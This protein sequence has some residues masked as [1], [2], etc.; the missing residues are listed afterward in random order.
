M[1]LLNLEGFEN[2]AKVVGKKLDGLVRGTRVFALEVVAEVMTS[3]WCY[4]IVE[5]DRKESG[6]LI[7]KLV[8]P[9]EF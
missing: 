9:C 7:R 4:A 6:V 8:A 1:F 3:Q 2:V 5:L